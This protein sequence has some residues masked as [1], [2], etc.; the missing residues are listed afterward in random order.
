MKRVSTSPDEY[1]ASLPEEIRGDMTALDRRIA[2]ALPGHRRS[3]WEGVFWG[4]SAQTIIGYG[5]Y[6]Y[7]RSDKKPV[8]WF[9]V[10]LARQKN[11]Y[12]VYVNA[13]DGRRYLTDA[14]AG[15]ARQGQGRQEQHRL[16]PPR[17]GRDG[18]ADGA[19]RARRGADERR[20]AG[21]TE[22]FGTRLLLITN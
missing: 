13:A 11:Y 19:G 14:Y 8:E 2:A 1:L 22:P 7:V 9:I 18:G 16:P 15:P 17:R 5:D 20:R 21:V 6:S 12:S 10:G 4:G 3:L